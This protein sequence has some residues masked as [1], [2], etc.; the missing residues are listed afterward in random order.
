[1][2]QA[3]ALLGARCHAL[4]GGDLL[5]VGLA[6]GQAVAHFAKRAL[7][8][9]LV[10]LHRHLA[11]DARQ[12]QFGAQLAALEQRLRELR[13]KRPAARATTEQVAH[14]GTG[15]AQRGGERQARKEG[16]TRGADFRIGC[17][18]ALL[19]LQDIGPAQQQIGR[20]AGRQLRQHGLP[21]ER[22]PG[23]Q[24]LRHGG[25][26]QQFQA[27]VRQLARAYTR[28]HVGFGGGRLA[29]GLRHIEAAALAGRMQALRD[30]QRLAPVLQ[31][32]LRQL[33][34]GDGQPLFQVG[35]GHGGD[36][37]QLRRAPALLAG[38][39]TGEGGVGQRTQ[40]SEQVDLEGAHG[41]AGRK[42][43][44]HRVRRP[45]GHTLAHAAGTGA[46]GGQARAVLDLV[47]GAHGLHVQRRHAQVAV[48]GQRQ[49][50]QALQ[51]RVGQHP[52]PAQVGRIGA[53]R[54]LGG[55]IGRRHRQGR[56]DQRRRQGTRRQDS[57]QRGRQQDKTGPHHASPCTAG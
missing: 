22:Q 40:P 2:R 14:F 4:L 52:A 15:K 24:V 38:Q 28:L 5:R 41:H 7:D 46:D 47:L 36:Q 29:F 8:R 25:S 6:A 31:G 49:L 50:D 20:Q 42:L 27:V 51:A 33:Q 23:R 32:R 43:A 37:G 19:G 9:L 35:V 16:G 39:V 13:R 54:R 57:R 3:P 11:A 45:L 44:L 18:Q 56:L 48:V 1:M 17:H 26:Q 30:R 10:L 21:V 12:P 53:A 55:S 34:L